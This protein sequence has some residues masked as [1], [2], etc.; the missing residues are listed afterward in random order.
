MR[1][2]WTIHH[3]IAQTLALAALAVALVPPAAA[4]TLKVPQNYSTIQAALDGAAPGDTVLVSPKIGPG[5]KSYHEALT[6]A[7]SL[8][9]QGGSGATLD[10][11]GL[12]GFD[13]IDITA[14]HVAVRGLTVR[15]F[16]GDPFS[17]TAAIAVG[18]FNDDYSA[19][20]AAA[21][22]EISG[23]TLHRNHKGVSILGFIGD[24][25][26]SGGLGVPTTGYKLWNDTVTDNDSDGAQVSGGAIV[27]SGC[28]F[29]RNGLN[30]FDSTG[31]GLD[32]A[33]FGLTVAANEF[34]ANGNQGV[35]VSAA[36]DGPSAS[37]NAVAL[38]VVRNNAGYGLAACGALT[39]T[40]NAVS[41]NG[42]YGIY[43]AGAGNATVAFNLVTQNQP[44]DTAQPGDPYEAGVGIYVDYDA[45][46][47]ATCAPLPLTITAN[48]VRGNASDGIALN[49]ADLCLL[50]ANIVT[51]NGGIGI[52]LS[53]WTGF[54]AP[55]TVTGNVGRG[56]TPYDAQ[57]DVALEDGG[58]TPNVWTKNRFAAPN[59][60]GQ[61]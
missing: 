52:H 59:L 30:N 29:A 5:D 35:N 40:G 32:V 13:G 47:P 56:N 42:G 17:D 31:D 7:K 24:N 26:Y 10:G 4:K 55:N 41:H 19:F 36:L 50:S 37:P 39:V 22:V 20:A 58:A 53:D 60:P 16:G 27:V 28:R 23:C 6:I 34:R 3:N 33:G 12:D 54:D 2:V 9:L 61:P 46:D 43:L 51:G 25:P 11:T 38:N 15:N 21:D 45:Y 48:D 8:T 14:D 18:F 49:S 44:L 57:D 1:P